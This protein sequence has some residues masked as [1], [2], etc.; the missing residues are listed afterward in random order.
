ME[1]F[2]TLF[3]GLVLPSPPSKRRVGRLLI[4]DWKPL[5][6]SGWRGFR[7][8]W[9]HADH[10]PAE[11]PLF[12]GIYSVG[13]RWIAPWADMSFHLQAYCPRCA[14][15]LTLQEKDAIRLLRVWATLIPPNGHIAIEYE[16]P[17]HEETHHG[18][19]RGF[20][21]VLTPL[22]FW[23]WQGGFRGGFKDWY[24]AEG[25][26]EGPR[27][28]QINQAADN[29]HA[30]RVRQLL[31]EQVKAFLERRT[32]EPD[33]IE[34]RARARARKWLGKIAPQGILTTERMEGASL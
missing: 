6:L 29:S 31:Q 25:G 13:N 10:P 4:T 33:E 1:N 32:H 17:E 9:C 22:G 30:R 5:R 26:H 19:Q 34:Q 7:L 3:E 23:A 28:L 21:A 8:Q 12:W 18:L 11:P 15:L 14:Y 27:K 20:P 24:L 2:F 16:S